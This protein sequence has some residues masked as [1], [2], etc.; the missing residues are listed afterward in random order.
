M[1]GWPHIY[2][3]IYILLLIIIIII[4][5][6]VYPI[7]RNIIYIPGEITMHHV[8]TSREVTME[9]D[10]MEELVADLQHL[11]HDPDDVGSFRPAETMWAL[12]GV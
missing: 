1:G 10:A 2:T 7:V 4:I 6:I 9:G 12:N 3:Y 5:I 8:E 11:F